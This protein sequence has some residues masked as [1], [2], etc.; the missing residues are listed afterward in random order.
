M[1]IVKSQ[2]CG[3]H[4]AFTAKPAR[5]FLSPAWLHRKRRFKI[6]DSSPQLFLASKL[7]RSSASD[8]ES[9]LF[10]V[11]SA[12]NEGWFEAPWRLK[13]GAARYGDQGCT[14]GFYEVSVIRA[15]IIRVP[16]F[17]QRVGKGCGHRPTISFRHILSTHWYIFIKRNS[18]LIQRL[19][20][21]RQGVTFL[22]WARASCRIFPAL[23]DNFLLA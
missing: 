23:S 16:I 4:F 15:G 18:S 3:M 20:T 5:N 9:C 19:F 7:N 12:G 1:E 14:K 21:T 22:P 6:L 11:K 13:I 8:K 2:N 17:A 10:K